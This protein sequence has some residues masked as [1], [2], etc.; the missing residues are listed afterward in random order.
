MPDI[1]SIEQF[2]QQL[3]SIGDEPAILAERGEQIENIEPPEE[4]LPADLDE[5]L[6]GAAEDV[7]EAEEA[8]EAEE[9]EEAEEIPDFE[10]VEEEPAEKAGEAVEAEETEEPEAEEELELEPEGEPEPEEEFESF[11]SSELGTAEEL[12][13]LPDDF[14]FGLPEEGEPGEG[15]EEQAGEEAEELPDF[16]ELG[17]EEAGEAAGEEPEEFGELGEED[18]DLGIPE[19]PAEEEFETGEAPAADFG[20]EEEEGEEE[21][22]GEATAEET[23]TEEGEEFGELGELEETGLDDEDFSF[24]EFSL[25]GIGDE[26]G[27]TSEEG[28]EELAPFAAEESE[29][30]EEAEEAIEEAEAAELSLSDQDFLAVKRTLAGLPRNLKLAIEEL[31]GE[32]ELGGERLSKLTT[33][34]IEGE[35]P[36]AL[37]AYVGRITGK[38]INIP[39]GYE[40]K[41]TRELEEEQQTFG[42]FFRTRIFPV[43]RTVLI[44]AVIGVLL[45]VLGRRFIYAPI[46]AKNLYEEGYEYLLQEE[47]ERA[48][49]RFV[50]ATER[51]AR[52]HGRTRLMRKWY[53]RYAQ[54]YTDTRQYDFAEHKYLQII[55]GMSLLNEVLPEGGPS[56]DPDIAWRKITERY[57]NVPPELNQAHPDHQQFLRNPAGWFP[58]FSWDRLPFIELGRL[59]SRYLAKYDS[60]E[61]LFTAVLEEDYTDYDGLILSGDNYLR[62]ARSYPADTQTALEKYDQARR[63]YAE[64]YSRHGGSSKG[65]EI[66]H[67]LLYYFIS[68]DR[69]TDGTTGDL[70]YFSS[71]LG[72]AGAMTSDSSWPINPF[73]VALTADYFFDAGSP[74]DMNELLTAALNR[75]SV[76]DQAPE[77]HYELARYYGFFEE[78]ERE[79]STLQNALSRLEQEEQQ[80]KEGREPLWLTDAH[81]SFP[82]REER[83]SL[84]AEADVLVRNRLGE[85]AYGD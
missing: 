39:R 38:T 65:Y 2:K 74:Q 7:G 52:P 60:A 23:E 41:S 1:Q 70:D 55:S 9:P 12:D 14:Q 54:G 17:E 46:M 31:V 10:E 83:R 50:R 34:L 13:S 59:E 44:L 56:V 51:W 77:L 6:G 67:R 76:L 35:S 22:A 64:L 48:E 82:F 53:Y 61:S 43:L 79:R 19:E 36:K 72:I 85:I 15:V 24:D 5:L 25:E 4:G 78:P 58:P 8:E 62:W 28:A 18:F 16:E 21:E 33:M 3:N 63:S 29:T 73:L 68:A 37:A 57:A 49:S 11:D 30:T 69:E 71:I 20:E 81:R 26:F 45:F 40:R 84:V 27:I 32:E 75:R 42:Y 80:R 66:Q 47:P